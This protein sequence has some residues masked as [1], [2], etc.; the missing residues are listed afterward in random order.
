M[1]VLIVSTSD[2]QGGAAIAAYRLMQALNANG[3]DSKMMVCRKKTSDKRVV[4]IGSKR[5]TD[6]KFYAERWFIFRKNAFSRKHLFDVSTANTGY[7]IVDTP[8]FREADVIHLHWINQG[9]LSLTA[10][11]QILKSGKK[12]VW[13][14]HDMWTITGICHHTQVHGEHLSTFNSCPY[15]GKRLDKLSHLVFDEKQRVYASGNVSFVAC[16]QWLEK[17]AAVSPLTQGQQVV[18][19]P[20]PIDTQQY[21]PANKDEV[22]ERLK[23]AKDKKYIL[24]AAAKV[25]DKRKGLDYLLAADKILS[26]MKQDIV[27]LIAGAEGEKVSTALISKSTHLG[28]VPFDKMTD[29]Y[30]AADIFLTP[31]LFENLPNTIM[32]AMACGTP[33]VGFDVGG[34]PEMI[35]HKKNG[36]VCQYQDAEALAKGILWT[37]FEADYRVLSINAREKVLLNYS[38]EIVSGKYLKIYGK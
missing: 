8:Q 30:R 26:K 36:Y 17:L 9:M 33:C 3:V 1:K 25:S 38:Q 14:M 16:S 19:I 10:I 15:F 24:Y 4:G 37:L 7:S 32:E 18:S 31:S 12:V 27:F 5:K 34:I 22:R 2:V 20:N 21:S 29:Y 6:W 23:L 35:D 13:T 28:Y 11:G